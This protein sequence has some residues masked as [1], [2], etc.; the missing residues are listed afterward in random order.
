M[1]ALAPVQVALGRLV[2]GLIPL[3]AVLAFRRD[4]VPRDLRTWGHLFVGALLL[5]AGPFTL[6]AYGETQV[7]SVLAGIWNATTPLLTAAVAMLALPDERPTR[8]RVAGLLVGFAG[9]LVVLGA[10][11]GVGGHALLGNLACLAAAACYGLGF[12]YTRRHL[13]GRPESVVSL[14]AA[15]LLCATAQLA[16]VAPLVS[17]APRGLPAR[18][19][20]SVVA[21]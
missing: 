10:W 16:V 2:L 21:L 19:V 17:G 1:G 3:L 7:S 18:V 9:V 8:A 20:L 14:S 5:S 4:P 15:Q 6:Y 11:R 13:A 12:P